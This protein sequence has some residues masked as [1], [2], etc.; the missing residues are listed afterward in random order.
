MIVLLFTL[1]IKKQKQKQNLTLKF[2]EV[3]ELGI[4]ATFFSD[5]NC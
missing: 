2:A 3:D 5:L 1:G 4:R